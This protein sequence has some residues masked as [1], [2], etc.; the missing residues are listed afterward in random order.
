MLKRI[1]FYAQSDRIGDTAVADYKVWTREDRKL[2]RAA[3]SGT[4][5]DTALAVAQSFTDTAIVPSEA[6][7][8]RARLATDEKYGTCIRWLL[9]ARCCTAIAP[10]VAR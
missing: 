1:W 7:V 8:T 9:V 3:Y 2:C 5:Y 4:D 10:R 6:W